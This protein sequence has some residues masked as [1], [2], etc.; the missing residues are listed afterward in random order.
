MPRQL[1]K[2]HSDRTFTLTK[3]SSV[4]VEKVLRKEILGVTA[5]FSK[6]SKAD[7]QRSLNKIVANTSHEFVFT[8]SVSHLKRLLLVQYFFQKKIEI[9][10][11]QGSKEESHLLIKIF[12]IDSY[13][14]CV[15]AMFYSPQEDEYFS[16]N[17]IRKELDL[18]IP[19][20]ETIAHSF[21]SWWDPVLSYRFYYFEI[22]KVRGKVLHSKELKRIANQLQK[23]ILYLPSRPSVFLPYNAEEA[24]RQLLLLKKEISNV[25]DLPQA[26]LHFRGQNH[27]Y[28]EFFV[29]LVCPEKKAFVLENTAR[30]P[31]EVR[32]VV[33]FQ[34]TK[35]SNFP[36]ESLVLSIQIPITSF[37]ENNA[38]NLIQARRAA[39]RYLEDL[40]GSF[41]DYNGGLFEIQEKHFELFKN[42]LSEK[43]PNFS[44]FAE[45]LF[46]SIKPIESQLNI[47]IEILENL[48]L[49]FSKVYEHK[50]EIEIVENNIS[51]IK[52]KKP[53]FKLKKEDAYA[54]AYLEL[55]GFY[56][57]CFINQVKV[58]Y[59]A[60]PEKKINTLRLNFL[61][62]PPISLNPWLIYTE[63]RCRFLCKALFEGLTRLD[64]NG[65]FSLAGAESYQKSADELTYLFKIRPHYWSNGEKVT[66]H[67]Y[68]KSWKQALFS[69]DVP[70]EP[71]LI[72]KHAKKIKAG[73]SPVSMLGVKAL[74][75]KTLYIELERPDPYFLEKLAHPLFFPLL[76]P[77]QEP[78]QFNGPY[79]FLSKSDKELV[80]ERN[81]YYWDRENIFFNQIRIEWGK[82]SHEIHQSFLEGA[83]DWI[84]TP[85]SR[86]PNELL[87]VLR[88]KGELKEKTV[89]RALYI[90][91][92]THHPLFCSPTIRH[93]FN[94]AL[95]RPWI[96][97]NIF[98][99]DIL[100]PG[101]L[102]MGISSITVEHEQHTISYLKESF[103]K[104]VE[105]LGLKENHL[106]PIYFNYY[107]TPGHSQLVDYLK[108]RWE[109]IFN[110]PIILQGMPWNALC[111]AV[112]RR[113]FHLAEST[114]SA[115][116]KDPLDLLQRF[117]HKHSPYN[118]PGWSDP[119]FQKKLEEVRYCQALDQRQK[120][121]QEA[122]EYLHQQLPFIPI[123]NRKFIYATSSALV[124]YV[125]DPTGTLD[126]RWAK[127]RNKDE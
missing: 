79:L 122:E 74:D 19:G 6:F 14:I 37:L 9:L 21:F 98:P 83:L 26:S 11:K 115:F 106:S 65:N 51:I 86:F 108:E 94:A 70:L 68:E 62:G 44:I 48:F 22:Q 55:F 118:F 99:R 113:N 42:K 24:Y 10:I 76:V 49:L 81:P 114:E 15:S 39:S 35:K 1:I 63:I 121:L 120:L 13:K 73:T 82:G 105:N 127:F 60:L 36:V 7:L 104:A 17:Q 30:L 109:K 50:K 89:A 3:H 102:P 8:R 54:H 46:Y 47:S 125:I 91:F 107:L 95:N 43:I 111:S 71:F 124:D 18:L 103:K 28:L 100:L 80:L 32:V 77:H 29:Y 5:R 25:D 52:L 33:H 41:R 61:E 66:A 116:S 92:N 90:F 2:T 123:V 40:M 34:Q 64:L 126:F 110:V 4:G 112:S 117:E 16:L 75:D 97:K 84:G 27:A 69:S 56:Y 119:V 31:S 53:L 20:L 12:T 58:P 38:I 23:K 59:L 87:T 88:D 72:L 45:K 101:F 67:H 57:Y 96:A 78:K 85:F 93:L